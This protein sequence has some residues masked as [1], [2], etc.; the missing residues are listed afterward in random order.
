[1]HRAGLLSL[2][3]LLYASL[4]CACLELN[5]CPPPPQAA[6]I[7][8][9]AGHYSSRG[10]QAAAA[11]HTVPSCCCCLHH[12]S[13]WAGCSAPPLQPNLSYWAGER[14]QGASELTVVPH[15]LSSAACLQGP[16][17]SCGPVYALQQPDS[18]VGT[19]ARVL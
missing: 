19:V 8:L 16:F 4:R 13:C 14:Q 10:G 3:S 15:L 17:S 7:K 5:C 1:M 2:S 12:L 18:R 6:E 11:D 9:L